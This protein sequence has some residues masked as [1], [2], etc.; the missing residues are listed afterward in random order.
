M[1]MRI[2]SPEPADS[3]AHYNGFK[4]NADSEE[5]QGL[6]C[7]RR[8]TAGRQ[9]G[10]HKNITVFFLTEPGVSSFGIHLIN[11]TITHGFQD[12]V[13]LGESAD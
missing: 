12:F 8:S 9:E 3:K 4:K 13:A 2:N 6:M 10:D 5:T 1:E 11:F 7:M